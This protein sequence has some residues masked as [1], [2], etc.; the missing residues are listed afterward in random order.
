MHQESL[1]PRCLSPEG[2]RLVFLGFLLSPSLYWIANDNQIWPWDMSWYGEA[3]ADLWFVLTHFPE[4][5]LAAL[6]GVFSAKAPGIAWFGQFFVP[7]GRLFGSIEFGLLVS[8]ILF[9]L[10]SLILVYKTGRELVT[11]RSRLAFLGA[12]AVASSPLFV[13]MSHQYLAEAH[14]LFA[15]AYFYWIAAKAPKLRRVRIL[16]HLLLATALAMLSKVSSPLYCLLPACIALDAILTL[17]LPRAPQRALKDGLLLIAGA[18][19]LIGAAGWYFDNFSAVFEFVKE[20][21]S[22][23]TA[24]NY[25][26]KDLFAN[27]L[28]FWLAAAQNSFA[29]PE[30]VATT[31][32]AVLAGIA[33]AAVRMRKTKTRPGLDRFSAL[34]IAALLHVMIVFAVFSLSINEESRYLLPLLP[35][36]VIL[37]LW[38][39]SH[40]RNRW[41]E[42][43]L[44]AAF[45]FQWGF[46]HARALGLASR[47]EEIS[48]W[49]IPLHRDAK[50]KE[51]I[52]RLIKL[53]C[54]PQT[55]ER[56]NISG[57]ELPWL[58]AD[59][60][61]FYMAKE[62]L[63]GKI[64][65]HYTSLGYTEKDVRRAL[66]R[67]DQL[68][69]AHFISLNEPAHPQPPNFLNQ[70][71]LPVLQ[72]IRKDKRYVQ[73]PFDSE[74]NI[75][76]FR[77]KG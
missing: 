26:K 65:C 39:L 18:A 28:K 35:S 7:M 24:L 69:I 8:V 44:L 30:L 12:L 19:L 58:N 17:D 38:C 15:V 36:L 5:W 50:A 74:L 61:S 73:Q 54:T 56:Y 76:V 2:W 20:A 21:S 14:Q 31:A 49:V 41:V 3:S 60:L 46:V 45:F 64:R 70:V 68:D 62:R 9:Q 23:D 66:A 27:K 40:V 55:A 11:N 59:S 77:R 10:G 72:A 47:S 53:T 42:I 22:G 37:L 52:Q 25:G 75:I 48:Y 4:Q 34:A 57:V 1:F 32:I 6:M 16:G 33:M 67:I 43:A 51:E 71:S 13:A 63:R 29:L